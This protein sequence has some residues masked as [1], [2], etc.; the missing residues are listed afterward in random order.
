M[1]GPVGVLIG[2]YLVHSPRRQR[3]FF[4]SAAIGTGYGWW[5]GTPEINSFDSAGRRVHGSGFDP[6]ALLHLAPEVGYRSSGT[7]SGAPSRTASAVSSSGSCWE[8]TSAS[9]RA[10]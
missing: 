7:I 2:L 10:R 3:R 1:I 5:K 9:T 4:L 6:A 8:R